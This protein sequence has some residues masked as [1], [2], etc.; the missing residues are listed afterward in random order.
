MENRRLNEPGSQNGRAATVGTEQWATHWSAA[1]SNRIGSE[2][3]NDPTNGH[4]LGLV[5]IDLLDAVVVVKV[6]PPTF[7][8]THV[9][10]DVVGAGTFTFAVTRLKSL[11]RTHRPKR[12]ASPFS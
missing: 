6:F 8:L 1:E 5:C 12:G 3:P 11:A 9:H 2:P 10:C 4:P 7:T